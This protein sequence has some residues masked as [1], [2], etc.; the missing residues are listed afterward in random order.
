MN[1]FQLT[2]LEVHE[3]SFRQSLTL[4]GVMVEYGRASEQADSE[5]R[6]YKDRSLSDKDMG[7]LPLF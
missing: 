3:H 4:P 2:A 7:S 6:T 1:L 5:E